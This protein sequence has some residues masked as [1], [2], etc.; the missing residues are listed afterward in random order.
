MK[1]NETDLITV[2]RS[3]KPG[4]CH[5]IGGSDARVVKAWTKLRGSDC[6]PAITA[7]LT[8]PNPN[9]AGSALAANSGQVLA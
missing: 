1:I 6:G 2:P 8:P 5:F 3:R 7:L 4:H 9:G